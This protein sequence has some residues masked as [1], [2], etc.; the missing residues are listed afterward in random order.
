MINMT[1]AP[2]T[3]ARIQLALNVKD[4]DAAVAFYTKMF[5]T[6]PAKIRPGYANFAVANPPLKLVLFEGAEEGTINHLGVEVSS[7][8]EVIEAETR[9]IEA[10]LETTGIDN[11]VCC[12]AEKTETWL[13]GP[14]ATRW[15]WYVRHGDADQLENTIIDNANSASASDIT[16][17]PTVAK[18]AAPSPTICCS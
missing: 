7:S 15:E 5:G 18:D 8:E 17:C 9:L 13:H 14:D 11:T 4:L 16:C 3:T 2:P 6:E 12:Y 1:E 10:G